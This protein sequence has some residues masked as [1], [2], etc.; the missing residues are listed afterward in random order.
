MSISKSLLVIIEESYFLLKNPRAD[1]RKEPPASPPHQANTQQRPRTAQNSPLI[2]GTEAGS[3]SSGSS[4]W[5]PAELD[6]GVGAP[7]PRFSNFANP[8]EGL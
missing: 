3:A 6:G 1:C 5:P 2:E 8:G 7:E 4:V